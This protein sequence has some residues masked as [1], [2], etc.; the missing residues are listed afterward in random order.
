MKGMPADVDLED[1]LAEFD[2]VR[3]RLFGIAYR[4]LGRVVEAEDVVQDAW[5]KWQ[6][7]DR[8]GVRVPAAFLSTMTTRLALNV[9]QSA[10]ARRETYLGPWV[11]EPVDTSLD[12]LLGAERGEALELALLMLLE[13]LTPRERAAYVLHEAFAYPFADIGAVLTIGEAA[14]R[15]LVSRARKHLA[16][17]RS[18]RVD[19]QEQRRLL[20]AFIAAA[21][22]GDV[23]A[24]EALLT[25]DVVTYSDGGGVASAARRPV[26]GR[27]RVAAFIT[28]IAAKLGPG[29]Q[30]LRIEANGLSSMLF[31]RGDEIYAFGTV[32][33]SAD[34]IDRVLLVLNPAKL[35][36]IAQHASDASGESVR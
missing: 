13:K 17:E 34:G 4:M 1:A 12:P 18:A 20:D 22:S 27:A 25:E 9:A 33:A 29:Q 6:A 8:A 10:H 31:T 23:A 26:F 11:P 7:T 21:G 14:A 28:G 19:P 24:L 30:V 36:T 16:D 35:T 15:Q 3:P 2:A 32:D 5:L